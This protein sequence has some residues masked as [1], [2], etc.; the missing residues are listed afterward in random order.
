[1]AY[2]LAIDI[3]TSSTKAC[4]FNETGDLLHRERITY[5]TH[6]L[7][8]GFQEQDPD[9]LVK[10]VEQAIRDLIRQQKEQPMGI[11]FSCA[12][13]SVIAVDEKGQPLTP[14][15]IWAD[16]RSTKYAEEL[17]HSQT[18]TAIYHHTGTPLHPM[19]P[20]CKIAWLR[21][22]AP[23]V[24][25]QTAKFISIKEYLLHHWFGQYVVDYSIASATGLFDVEKLEWYAPALDFAGI[26][27]EHLSKPVPPEHILSDW[28]TTILQQ[29]KLKAEVPIVIGASDGCLANLGE[30]VT[31]KGDLVISL[32][33]SGA[34][35][36][37]GTTK[38][39]DDQ[40][41][42]FNYILTQGQYVIGG[43]TNNGGVIFQWFSELLNQEPDEL[44]KLELEAAALP[45]GAN[46]LLFLPYLLGERAPVWDAKAR[47]AYLGLT[48]QHGQA[49]LLRSLLEGVVFNLWHITQSFA[50]EEGAVQNIYA[51]GGFTQSEPA[52]QIL[53]DV[54][55]VPVH[56][57]EHEESAA[58]GAAILGMKAIRRLDDWPDL[59]KAEIEQIFQPDAEKHERYQSIFA[60][61]CELSDKLL[62]DL[63]KIAILGKSNTTKPA[64]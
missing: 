61:Y 40:H 63:R 64:S 11:A 36:T 21:D 24:F 2:F 54:F 57:Q 53:A 23:E 28:K 51:N 25:Q 58:W 15:I 59:P 56:L 13:H 37:T 19:S 55:G 41:R 1:M 44:E 4:A 46:G 22:E 12:M 52:M 35:R 8:P 17:R 48:R 10:A 49:H 26:K 60:L 32:G 33:T 18:G 43:P 27:P 5:P 31:G 9:T 38:V 50:S 45:P 34:V 62:P 20:L 16:S 42:I 29:L 6:S 47:G 7:Q 30:Q 14:C 3:G 39:M